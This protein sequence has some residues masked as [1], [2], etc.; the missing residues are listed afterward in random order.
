MHGQP[1]RVG[2]DNRLDVRPIG[3]RDTDIGNL[4]QLIGIFD[5]YKC[6]AGQDDFQNGH[7][8][9]MGQFDAA[10]KNSGGAVRLSQQHEQFFK[11][12]CGIFAVAACVE[13]SGHFGLAV[14]GLY[15]FIKWFADEGSS[16]Q[17]GQGNPVKDGNQI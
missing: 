5:G 9:Q 16:R 11:E 8:H 6:I 7:E 14:T 3:L 13:K 10:D 2:I 17:N 1:D 12:S 4:F 15:D